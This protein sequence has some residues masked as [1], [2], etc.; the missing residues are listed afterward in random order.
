MRCKG[1]AKWR[2]DP[3]ILTLKLASL[4]ARLKVNRPFLWKM[5]DIANT[6]RVGTMSLAGDLYQIG[7]ALVTG[8]LKK[9][10]ATED[11]SNIDR[12]DLLALRRVSHLLRSPFCV[13]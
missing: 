7:Y 4:E 11:Y 12:S 13:L 6:T 3:D 5:L 9:S 2:Q 8:G 1:Y 10:R